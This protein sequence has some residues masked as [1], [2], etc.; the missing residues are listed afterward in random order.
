MV[1]KCIEIIDFEIFMSLK[2]SFYVLNSNDGG[3]LEI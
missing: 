1:L 2:L 3:M